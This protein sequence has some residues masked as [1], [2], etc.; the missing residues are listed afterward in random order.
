MKSVYAACPAR[1]LKDSTELGN[2]NR[3]QTA[4]D[5]QMKSIG[6]FVELCKPLLGRWPERI[7]PRLVY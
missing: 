5:P 2:Q 4:I 6:D 3:L 7:T 1:N